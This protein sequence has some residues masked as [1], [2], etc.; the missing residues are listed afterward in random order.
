MSTAK[1]WSRE[2]DSASDNARPFAL[3]LEPETVSFSATS[4]LTDPSQPA[5]SVQSE[6]ARRTGATFG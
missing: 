6:Q 1:K 2:S 3:N 5:A 4:V